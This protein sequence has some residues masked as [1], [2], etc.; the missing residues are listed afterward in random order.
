MRDTT[1][2][3]EPARAADAPGIIRLIERVFVE[4]GFVFAADTEVPD[5]LA[6]GHHYHPPRGAFFVI[7]DVGR[8]VGSV[9]VERLAAHRAELHRLYLD[10]A[11]RG[12]G[13]GRAL[14]E[15]VIAWCRLEDIPHLTL[16]SDTRFDRAHALYARLGFRRTGERTLAGDPNQTREYRYE[17]SL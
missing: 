14:V 3:V 4:Y 10:P 2:T 12:H 16:W 15:R 6:F 17:L 13:L 7:R 11:L 8:V 5:L 1:L 9:G